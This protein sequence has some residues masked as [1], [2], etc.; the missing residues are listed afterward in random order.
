MLPFR[1]AH[2]TARHRLCNFMYSSPGCR[3]GSSTPAC[4]N[5]G[6]RTLSGTGIVGHRR[7]DAATHHSL[8]RPNAGAGPLGTAVISFCAAPAPQTTLPAG[9]LGLPIFARGPCR[10]PFH[11]SIHT[12]VPPRPVMRDTLRA[13]LPRPAQGCASLE[14]DLAFWRGN[15]GE[16]SA[17]NNQRRRLFR[18][19]DDTPAR[20]S[21]P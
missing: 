18:G 12:A 4:S 10:P 1:C 9:T 17:S 5:H 6:R 13:R 7:S 2:C 3:P 8:L 15:A 14:A 11:C 16:N 20:N 21:C 19:H